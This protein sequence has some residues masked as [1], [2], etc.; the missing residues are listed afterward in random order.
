MPVE[1]VTFK[2]NSTSAIATL[3]QGLAHPRQHF[4]L[5]SHLPV[6]IFFVLR[7]RSFLCR[8]PSGKG[9]HFGA[10]NHYTVCFLGFA[11]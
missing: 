5:L 2:F 7:R 1:V 3:Y 11:V 4:V 8:V 9:A 6:R 10:G